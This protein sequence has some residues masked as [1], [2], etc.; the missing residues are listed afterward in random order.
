MIAKPKVKKEGYFLHK[1]VMI[2][3]ASSGVGRALAYWYLNNGAQVAL[4]GRD[5]S[6]LDRI[7]A[8]Y[9]A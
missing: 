2:T 4:L 9:P 1:V 8:L 7:A 5:I 6:E 3:G